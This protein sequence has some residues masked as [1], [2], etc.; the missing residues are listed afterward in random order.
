MCNHQLIMTP[1]TRTRRI[2]ETAAIVRP[3]VER[4]EYCHA[5]WERPHLPCLND[6]RS[7]SWAK[8]EHGCTFAG[9]NVFSFI[10]SHREDSEIVYQ[11]RVRRHQHPEER[12]QG[13]VSHLVRPQ[14]D[15]YR[16]SAKMLINMQD[17]IPENRLFSFDLPR[18][19]EGTSVIGVSADLRLAD[20]DHRVLTDIPIKDQALHPYGRHTAV[21]VR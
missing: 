8:A 3:L 16:V 10:Q 1:L 14:E 11:D 21:P 4:C 12:L 13:Q 5:K 15:L 9:K 20:R 2:Y 17:I 18:Q 6:F 19:R 7:A